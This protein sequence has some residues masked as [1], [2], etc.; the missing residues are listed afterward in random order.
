MPTITLIGAGAMGAATGAR[1]TAAGLRVVSPLEGRSAE[2]VAR[3][4][5]AGMVAAEP[6]ELVQSDLILSI[7]PPGEAVKVAESLAPAL[8]E[9]PRKP[10]YVD[11]NAINPD[12]LYRVAQALRGTG[13]QLIDGGIIGGPP[14]VGGRSPAYYVSN[15]PEGRTDMLADHL[16]VRRIEGP[17]GAASALKMAY[18]GISKGL[19]GLGAAMYLAAGQSGTAELLRAQMAEDGGVLPRL[20]GG[21]PGMYAK[22]YRWVDEMNEIAGFLGSDDPAS[23]V[24]RALA[25]FYDQMAKDHAG[26]GELAAM[27]DA[28]LGV[29]PSG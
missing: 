2:T 12:T 14:V 23:G 27:M 29:R 18:A 22:A 4:E 9:G 19:I 24:F 26:E 6:A 15:D 5:A 8:R 16:D 20:Q 3:A 7:V 1:L 25:A 21:V 11:F 28:A 13:S 17:M 10:P